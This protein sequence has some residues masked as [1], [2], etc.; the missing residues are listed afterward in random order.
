[1]QIT[2][3]RSR[4]GDVES[5]VQWRLSLDSKVKPLQATSSLRTRAFSRNWKRL[6]S[7]IF[8]SSMSRPEVAD[9]DAK[10]IVRHLRTSEAQRTKS[11]RRTESRRMVHD[12]ILSRTS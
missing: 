9:E 2:L 10:S 11:R 12:A 1:M 8:Q 3:L 6:G 5:E 4:N 7:W